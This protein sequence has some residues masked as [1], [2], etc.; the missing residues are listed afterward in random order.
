MGFRRDVLKAAADEIA[1]APHV[2]WVEGPFK[3][4]DG[5]RY[6]EVQ[7]VSGKIYRVTIERVA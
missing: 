2:D 5:E 7:S 1:F 3:D 4:N 6:L